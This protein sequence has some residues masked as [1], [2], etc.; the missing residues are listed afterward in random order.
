MTPD[1]KELCALRQE[2]LKIDTVAAEIVPQKRRAANV[3]RPGMSC[4]A[5]ATAAAR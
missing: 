2:V 3:E 4:D 1:A 5:Y